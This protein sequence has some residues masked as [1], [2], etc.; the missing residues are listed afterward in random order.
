[1][2]EK[3]Q[4]CTRLLV[5]KISSTSTT[6]IQT[7]PGILLTVLDSTEESRFS[8]HG[9]EVGIT[10]IIKIKYASIYYYHYL[11]TGQVVLLKK[12]LGSSQFPHLHFCVRFFA[13]WPEPFN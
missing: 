3:F 1:M 9:L 4:Y 13:F 5:L 8:H 11:L 7:K 2:N 12:R 10:I 6:V